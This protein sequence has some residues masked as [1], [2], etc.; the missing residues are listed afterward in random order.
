M[1]GKSSVYVFGGCIYPHPRH[2]E[3]WFVDSL[4]VGCVVRDRVRAGGGVRETL[5]PPQFSPDRK[6]SVLAL[7]LRLNA[8]SSRVYS[9]SANNARN[10]NACHPL[11]HPRVHLSCETG[12]HSPTWQ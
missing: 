1:F 12:A 9:T 2:K 10:V 8:T 11:C 6:R 7:G 3:M 5:A 4:G